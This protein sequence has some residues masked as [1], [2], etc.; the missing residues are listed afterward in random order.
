ML[1]LA[2]PRE[3]LLQLLLL[4]WL[5]TGWPNGLASALA[6]IPQFLAD[7]GYTKGKKLVGVT[8]PRRVAAI[9][10]ATRVAA[11]RGVELGRQV[12]LI[13]VRPLLSQRMTFEL[14]A[15]WLL[16]PL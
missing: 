6:E 1:S 2:V 8:Q 15:G 10:V 4:L 5:F 14:V 11:E 16:D 7:A 12:R 9:S 3:K 13:N